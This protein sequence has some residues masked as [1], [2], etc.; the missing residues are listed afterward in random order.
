MLDLKEHS[1]IC[2]ILAHSEPGFRKNNYQTRAKSQDEKPKSLNPSC[3]LLWDGYILL[4][5]I[6]G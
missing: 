1:G 4:G 5:D 2:L 6:M 3:C